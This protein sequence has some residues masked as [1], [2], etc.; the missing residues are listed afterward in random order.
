MLRVPLLIL[1]ILSIVQF[2]SAGEVGVAVRCRR[3]APSM[4]SCGTK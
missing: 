2:P 4:P 3:P 1:C